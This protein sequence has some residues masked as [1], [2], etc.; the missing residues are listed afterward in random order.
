MY[1]NNIK[2][3]KNIRKNNIQN[4]TKN[5]NNNKNMIFSINATW[6]KFRS[7]ILQNTHLSI[8]IFDIFEKFE[9]GVVKFAQERREGVG[10][11][12]EEK[13]F[14][15]HGDR[16]RR[17]QLDDHVLFVAQEIDKSGIDGRLVNGR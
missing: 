8:A 15:D 3:N 14:D 9:Q 13:V 16:C 4:I 2:N 7:K 12:G 11:V 10:T 1:Q 17:R 5:N 6:P